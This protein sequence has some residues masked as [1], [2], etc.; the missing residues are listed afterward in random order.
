MKNSSTA[1]R[2]Y[3]T[4]QDAMTVAIG[5]IILGAEFLFTINTPTLE[6]E[7]YTLTV[8]DAE[9]DKLFLN[10]EKWLDD[11]DAISAVILGEPKPE[12]S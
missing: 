3:S 7:V 2:T 8:L 4:K 5:L 11:K 9:A 1:A 10:A 12:R 6:G